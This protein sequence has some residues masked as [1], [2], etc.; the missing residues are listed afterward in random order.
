MESPQLLSAYLDYDPEGV[1]LFRLSGHEQKRFARV[2]AA[3]RAA[4]P[5][6]DREW[7]PDRCAW[8]LFG[9]WDDELLEILEEFFEPEEVFVDG[10]PLRGDEDDGDLEP[11]FPGSRD[12]GAPE[13]VTG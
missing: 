3:F 10:R 7:A 4:V 9:G 1:V 6:A 13:P 12:R 11:A 2:L 5:A 8:M